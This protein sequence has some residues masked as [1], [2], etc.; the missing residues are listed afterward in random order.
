MYFCCHP[1]ILVDSQ[2]LILAVVIIEANAPERLLAVACLMED[3]KELSQ[4]EFI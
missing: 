3:I 4:L 1:Y 2:G